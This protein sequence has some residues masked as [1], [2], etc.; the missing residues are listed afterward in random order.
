MQE[1]LTTP[2][3]SVLFQQDHAAIIVNCFENERPLQGLIGALDW[4]FHGLLSQFVRSGTITGKKG[5]IVYIPAKKLDR[6]YHLFIVGGGVS[7]KT[8]QR[9]QTT[10][11][12]LEKVVENIKAVQAGHVVISNSDFGNF[13]DKDVVKSFGKK[14]Q[15]VQLWI[16]N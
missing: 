12:Y 6:H 8:G 5:E 15:G 4:R 7:N 10:L 3:D 14:L 1:V 9:T 16:A 11:N 2:A 13:E